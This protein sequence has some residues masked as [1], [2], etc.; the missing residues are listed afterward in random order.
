MRICPICNWEDDPLQFTDPNLGTGANSYPLIEAQ[1]NYERFGWMYEHASHAPHR[2]SE[3]ERDPRWRPIDPH[4]D[5]FSWF[6]N[7]DI[8]PVEDRV[9]HY[10]YWLEDQA[11]RGVG[12]G[13]STLSGR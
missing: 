11:A 6:H 7:I 13:W 12:Y 3:Y 2:E 10:Y 1:K 9:A 5:T 4:K 8:W